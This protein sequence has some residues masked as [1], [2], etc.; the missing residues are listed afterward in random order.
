MT[1]LEQYPWPGNVREFQ[2][3]LKQALLQTTGPVLAAEFLPAVLRKETP[4]S[5]PASGGSE[6]DLTRFIRERLAA[7][8]NDLHEEYTA[9][10][11]RHL[12]LQ[13]LEHTGN[14]LTQAAKVLGINR[15]TLRTRLEALGIRE[16]S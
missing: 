16:G 4:A 3:V 1:L 7:G 2:S 6:I 14:N 12:F 9:L 15:G 11:E 10:T 8:S 5:L 13:V